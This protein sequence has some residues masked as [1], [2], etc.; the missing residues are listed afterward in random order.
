MQKYDVS[1][2]LIDGTWMQRRD[3]EFTFDAENG[4]MYL[5]DD[6]G[7]QAFINFER[8]VQIGAIRVSA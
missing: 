3:T 5:F 2:Q 4:V 7:G 8:C 6:E 1:A